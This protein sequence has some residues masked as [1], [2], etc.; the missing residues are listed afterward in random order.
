MRRGFPGAFRQVS[1]AGQR[2]RQLHASAA[3][4]CDQVC[5]V[6]VR[7]SARV[8][9]TIAFIVRCLFHPVIS[10]FFMNRNAK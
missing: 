8:M 4:A 9:Q 2:R 3:L 6:F 5:K 1:P 7:D 10:H